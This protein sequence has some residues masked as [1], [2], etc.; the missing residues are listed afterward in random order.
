MQ[1][2]P[3]QAEAIKE[4]VLKPYREKAKHLA[5]YIEALTDEQAAAYPFDREVTQE[6]KSLQRAFGLTDKDVEAEEVR[7]LGE[8]I[9]VQKQ[10]QAQARVNEP[11]APFLQYPTFSFETVR[12]NEQ[13]AVIETIAGEAAYFTE[14]LGN[15]ITLDMVRIP[16]GK[17][18]MGAAQSEAGASADEY[19]QHEVRVPEFWMGKFAVTQEQWGAVASFTQIDRDLQREPAHFTGA[20]RPVEKVSWEEAMEFCKRLSQRSEREYTLPSEAQWEYACRAGT[21]TP[22]YFGPTVTIDLANYNSAHTYGKGPKGKYREQTTEVGR[23]WP[24]GFGLYD[25]HGNVWEWCLDDWHDSYK[26]AP[27][28]GSE[29]KSSGERKVLRGGSWHDDPTY[30]RAAFRLRTSRVLRSNTIGFRVISVSP[31]T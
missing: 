7:V 14:E 5:F 13:G 17:F 9:Q 22:F 4:E 19:P 31:R 8:R 29:W 18:L 21:T 2:T 1:I 20:K 28:D 30:C 16:G 3:E 12:V 25:M 27:A 10:P 11:S 24:N 15:G 6:F 23:L 26:G